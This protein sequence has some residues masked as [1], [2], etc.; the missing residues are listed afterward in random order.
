M[1]PKKVKTIIKKTSDD[2]NISESIVDDVISFYWKQVRESIVEVKSN[3]LKIN[4]LGTFNVKSWKLKGIID[5]YE[6]NIKS[7]NGYDN[8]YMTFQRH[9]ILSN[10]EKRLIKLQDLKEEI[11]KEEC[12]K[13]QI[14]KKRKE[15]VNNKNLES[16]ESDLGRNKE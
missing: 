5:K 1:T 3:S 8:K 14:K 12:R 7:L 6:K 16:K 4:G 15:Y 10:T 13:K 2:L 11:N 9:A